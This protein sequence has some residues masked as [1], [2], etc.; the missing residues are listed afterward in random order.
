MALLETFQFR[1]EVSMMCLL[2]VA[3]LQFSLA[4]HCLGAFQCC[5]F[6]VLTQKSLEKPWCALKPLPGRDHADAI[7]PMS[8]CSFATFVLP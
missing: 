8:G 4:R 1:R 6:L 3:L 2:S 7:H 5:L